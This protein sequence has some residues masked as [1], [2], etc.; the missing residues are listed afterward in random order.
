VKPQ[1]FILLFE[2]MGTHTHEKNNNNVV[3]HLPL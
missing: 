1:L 3:S 2:Q